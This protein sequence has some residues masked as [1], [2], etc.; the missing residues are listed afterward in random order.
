[1]YSQIFWSSASTFAMYSFAYDACCSKSCFLFCVKFVPLC[2]QPQLQTELPSQ[3]CEPSRSQPPSHVFPSSASFA[4]L[5]RSVAVCYTSCCCCITSLSTRLL[6]ASQ[7]QSPFQSQLG[8]L[9]L[10]RQPSILVLLP[11]VDDFPCP[12]LSSSVQPLSSRHCSPHTCRPA[13]GYALLACCWL[14]ALLACCW[15]FALLACC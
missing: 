1:M 9:L 5:Q 10:P 2:Q 11:C 8:V 15:L 4:A 6:S 13:V 12:C 7:L 14:F 3:P